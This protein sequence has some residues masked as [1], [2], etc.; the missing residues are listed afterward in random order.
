MVNFLQSMDKFWDVFCEPE[1]WPISML[2]TVLLY[3][4]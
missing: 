3:L 1:V 4:V 2:I